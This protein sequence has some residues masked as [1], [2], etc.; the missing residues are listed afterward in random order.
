VEQ[1]E[2]RH[3]G[4]GQGADHGADDV[5]N[6]R[7]HRTGEAEQR[8][9]AAVLERVLGAL[10][11]VEAVLE[12]AERAAAVGEVVEGSGNR[13][14]S[15]STLSTKRR[16]EQQPDAGHHDQRASEHHNTATRRGIRRCSGATAWSSARAMKLAIIPQLS[17][18]TVA[19]TS[20]QREHRH[21]HDADEHDDRAR[22]DR[23]AAAAVRHGRGPPG[24][25]CGR[26]RHGRPARRHRRQADSR[27]RAAPRSCARRRAI[28]GEGGG[29]RQRGGL[30]VAPNRPV[31]EAGKATTPSAGATARPAR[32][33]PRRTAASGS[34]SAQAISPPDGPPRS[35][36]GWYQ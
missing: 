13:M 10:D 20:P 3:E 9:G 4:H 8:A 36:P 17:T 27:P 22:V 30:P 34:A 25:R 5:G 28:G 32:S 26:P 29:D 19:A 15:A 11:D 7:E 2:Q 14:T 18:R 23:Q 24:D 31:P 6:R 1:H 16:D 21:Q 35:G 12:E 33:R